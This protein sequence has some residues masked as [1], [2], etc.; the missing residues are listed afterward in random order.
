MIV[1]SKIPPSLKCNYDVDDLEYCNI[2]Y[3]CIKN[4]NESTYHIP[5]NISQLV[6]SVISSINVLSHYM[7]D[8]DYRY[9]CYLTIKKMYVQP[10]GVGNRDGWHIDGFKSDQ[11]NFIWFDHIPTEVSIGEFELTNDHDKSLIEMRD[12]N[13]DNI[14]Q[15]DCNT[16]YDLDQNIIHRPNINNSDKSILR[17]FIKITYSKEL[18]NCFGNA[19]NYKLP[20]IRPN[21]HR[22]ENRNHGVL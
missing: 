8:N 4:I 19:W 3:M 7:Y 10:N 1:N 12:A 5:D 18:F 14:I 6:D 20:R 22:S 21:K 2:V 17:T 16:L 15:L 11:H 9:Y 13:H